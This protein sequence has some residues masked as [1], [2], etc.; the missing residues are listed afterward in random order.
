MW[1]GIRWADVGHR[2]RCDCIHV[3]YDW[4]WIKS[5]EVEQIDIYIY[6]YIYNM[7]K[8]FIHLISAGTLNMFKI[9][10]LHV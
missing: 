8:I 7:F 10:R 6:I 2:G 5:G 1:A 3:K 9:C 4:S